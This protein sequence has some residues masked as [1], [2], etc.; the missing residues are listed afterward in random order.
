MAF[1]FGTADATA[2]CVIPIG[3]GQSYIENFES[4]QMECWTVETTS[5]ATWAVMGGTNT[6]VVAFQNASAGDEARL[7]SPTFDMTGSSSATFS[8]G[9]AM[10]ALYPPYDELTV[11]YRTSPT[12][13]WH[14]L[15]S[16]SLS[17]WSNTYDELFTLEDLSSTFQI[18]FLGHC[19]G[20]YY[21]FIDDIEIAAAGGCARPMNLQVTEV[22]TSP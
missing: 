7:V 21:I 12:D 3:P 13:N 6:N 5:S 17:D 9:Y 16:Y 4:G 1:F 20:G 2:Q 14:Q 22:T 8:F 11:S 15:G 10:M 19:N 18:S